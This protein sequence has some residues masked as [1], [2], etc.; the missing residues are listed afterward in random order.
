MLAAILPL[1]GCDQEKAPSS[2]TSQDNNVNHSNL[3]PEIA[4]T[5]LSVESIASIHI[6]TRRIYRL[7]D[8]R[9]TGIVE[10]ISG[11]FKNKLLVVTSDPDDVYLLERVS[12]S[13]KLARDKDLKWV[14]A[15]KEDL[16]PVTL[17]P[18]GNGVAFIGKGAREIIYSDDLRG[19]ITKR[20]KVSGTAERFLAWTSL[21]DGVLYQT[22]GANSRSHLTLFDISRGRPR[23]DIEANARMSRRTSASFRGAKALIL[24]RELTPLRASSE[25]LRLIDTLNFERVVV[26]AELPSGKFLAQVVTKSPPNQGCTM[27]I[28]SM[29][30][31]QLS[32]FVVGPDKRPEDCLVNF[33]NLFF[34]YSFGEGNGM[35]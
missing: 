23:G 18:D 15:L 29:S 14:K 17:R 21:G 20:I 11:P 30:N 4:V 22:S 1:V 27:S 35:D 25:D 3:G 26:D 10:S 19:T 9:L 34:Q 31:A 16:S 12:G 33:G 24:E 7:D 32:L 28:G 8:S 5:D 13:W 6:P 2:T